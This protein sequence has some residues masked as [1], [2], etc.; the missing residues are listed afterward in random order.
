MEDN[1]IKW[2]EYTE[3]DTDFLVFEGDAYLD[4]KNSILFLSSWKDTYSTEKII[5]ISTCKKWNKSDYY[6]ILTDSGNM[7]IFKTFDGSE[8]H[9]DELKTLSKSIG[10]TMKYK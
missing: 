7:K 6:A 1:E 8:I 3:N 9:S 2:Y 5:D 4:N 10:C